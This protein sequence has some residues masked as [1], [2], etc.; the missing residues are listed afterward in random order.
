MRND[1]IHDVIEKYGTSIDGQLHVSGQ[2]ILA[3][4]QAFNGPFAWVGSGKSGG[5][6]VLRMRIA[7]LPQGIDPASP[8][9]EQ[10]ARLN[11]LYIE[12]AQV[13]AILVPAKV[14]SLSDPS[15]RKIVLG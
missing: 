10:H 5:E 11:D 12:A 3:G 9:A 1:D 6:T 4:G 15:G 7:V 8:E 13:V 14:S 2:V